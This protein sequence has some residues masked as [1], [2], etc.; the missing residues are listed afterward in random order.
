MIAF[1]HVSSVI[2]SIAQD[3]PEDRLQPGPSKKVILRVYNGRDGHDAYLATPK[4]I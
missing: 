1:V 2:S 4:I 3:T